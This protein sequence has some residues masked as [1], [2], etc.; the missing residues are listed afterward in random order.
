MFL[1]GRVLIN[2]LGLMAS[3]AP[4]LIGFNRRK[5]GSSN[6]SISEIILKD[7]LKAFIVLG[8]SLLKSLY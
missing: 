3:L 7:P 2:W 8:G 1:I 6:R 4:T 5:F